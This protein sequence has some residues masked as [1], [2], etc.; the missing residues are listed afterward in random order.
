MI[1]P[2]RIEETDS[3]QD[4]FLAMLPRIRRHAQL[5][6]RHLDCELRD[7]LVA[8][9]VAIAYCLF[10]GL[11][12]QG[13]R[14]VAYS[15]P[16]ANYAIRRVRS[17]RTASCPLNRNDVMSHYSRK[18]Q[19]LSIK[20]LESGDA[21]SGSWNQILVEDRHAGPA[22]TAAARIDVANWFRTLSR[23]DR[24]IAQML[25]NGERSSDVARQFKL[26]VG[27][28]SQL[29]GEFQRNWQQYQQRAA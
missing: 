21:A 19:G 13:R 8:E 7:E 23:R 1:A 17:G 26:S 20:Q 9:A 2:I 5:A 22:E 16:L 11:V 4:G 15:T 14:E 25:G 24:R 6:F 28:I 29:R 10:F 3:V 27:R 12:R 18:I